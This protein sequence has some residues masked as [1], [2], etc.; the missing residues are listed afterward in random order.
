M[1]SVEETMRMINGDTRPP[2]RIYGWLSGQ[3]SIARHYGGLR[4]QGHDYVIAYNEKDTP[5]VRIDVLAREAKEAKAAAKQG[6]AAMRAAHNAN[7]TKYFA[8]C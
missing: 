3:M 4:Y 8:N 2:E 5:L 6:G 1:N 7:V